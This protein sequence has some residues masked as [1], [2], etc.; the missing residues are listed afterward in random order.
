[1]E[2]SVS[3]A[4]I[5]SYMGRDF[6]EETRIVLGETQTCKGFIISQPIFYFQYVLFYEPFTVSNHIASTVGWFGKGMEESCVDLFQTTL[7]H[8]PGRAE[9][10]SHNSLRLCRNFKFKTL[11]LG[12]VVNTAVS[13]K[14]HPSIEQTYLTFDLWDLSHY[15]KCNTHYQLT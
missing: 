15:T 2:V 5:L 1:M 3:S 13:S 7:P 10:F 9:D 14:T 4:V 12:T 8:L 11:I 6:V